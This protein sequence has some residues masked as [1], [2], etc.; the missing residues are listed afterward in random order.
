M[1][2]GILTAEAGETQNPLLPAD[3]DILWSAVVFAVLLLFFWFRVLP[4]F[5][6][7]LD[8][9]A[10][11]I[12]GRLAE[13]ERATAEAAEKTNSIEAEQEKLRGEASSIR[14]EARAEGAAILTEMKEQARAESDR[15]AEVTKTQ[16]E[17]ERQ[18]A[19][20]SLRQEVGVLAIDLASKI[21]GEKLQED[22]VA[23]KV[24]DDFLS[25]IEKSKG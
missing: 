18:A 9:R 8:D 17:A 22:K 16:L 7:M 2:Y 15:I 11:A 19:I 5:K 20:E 10:E 12:E 14:E 4:S 13:A 23:N 24:V 25:E 21:V 6:K 1:L 3:Y